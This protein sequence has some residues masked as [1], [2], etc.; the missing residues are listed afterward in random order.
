MLRIMVNLP[1]LTVL[2]LA[3]LQIL[4]YGLVKIN[5]PT[6]C[7]FSPKFLSLHLVLLAWPVISCDLPPF[8]LTIDNLLQGQILAGEIPDVRHIQP[9]AHVENIRD[10]E[11]FTT[12]IMKF[13]MQPETV[14]VQIYFSGEE[15]EDLCLGI[16]L[17]Q[18][19]GHD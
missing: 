19:A 4:P 1:C 10:V 6:L 12:G 14:N 13:T 17:R 8:R 5:L 2:N 11:K 18:D 9:E 7:C 15:T 3:L 16:I